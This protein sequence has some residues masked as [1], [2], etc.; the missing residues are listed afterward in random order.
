[1]KITMVSLCMLLFPVLVWAGTLRDDFSDGNF[2]GWTLISF[3][4]D[5]G[6]CTVEKGKLVITRFS[7]WSCGCVIG[8]EDWKDY[9]IEFD[10]TLH[11]K[12]GTWSL[13]AMGLHLKGNAQQWRNAWMSY[14]FRPEG[15][16]AYI[17]AYDHPNFLQD[18][19]KPMPFEIGKTCHLK[20]VVSGN[21]YQLYIDNE[22][23]LQIQENRFP[24]GKVRLD[25]NG[26]VVS[27]DNVAITGD[28][29]PDKYLSVKPRGKLSIVWARLKTL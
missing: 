14:G 2:D 28:E 10:A 26:A 13:I 5:G 19:M 6:Q 15:I 11:Q 9:S 7:D 18:V 4:E 20:G 25:A 3:V 17:V 1:M 8:E 16:G 29:V 23:A 12:I 24:S 22:L 27:F 21:K